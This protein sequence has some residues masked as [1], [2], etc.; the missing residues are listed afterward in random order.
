[1]PVLPL[2]PSTIVPPGFKRPSFSARSMIGIPI[3]SLSE[4]PGLKNSALANTGVR[5]PRVTR[6]SRMSGVHPMS[7][8]T[9]VY[10]LRFR[11]AEDGVAEQWSRFRVPKEDRKENR[12]GDRLAVELRRNE[13]KIV[14]SDDGRGVERRIAARLVYACRVGRR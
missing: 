11:M 3:R 1:M 12:Y 4:P 10:G 8:S 13:M 6:P 5:I 2:V 7:S 9:F 14:G